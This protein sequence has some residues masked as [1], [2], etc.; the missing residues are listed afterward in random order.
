MIW[1]S[2]SLSA[3][4]SKSI[5]LSVPGSS[6]RAGAGAVTNRLDHAL[7]A[8]AIVLLNCTTLFCSARHSRHRDL[9]RRVHPLPIEPFEQ[10][11][12]LGCREPHHPVLDL[13]PA[14]LALFQPLG[15]ENDARAVPEDQ[16]DPVSSFG[17]EHVNRARERVGAHRLTHKRRE[18]IGPFAEVHRPGRH[19]DANSAG[20]PN[21]GPTFS[22]PITAAIA[23]GLAPDPIRSTVPSISTSI[24]MTGPCRRARRGCGAGGSGGREDGSTTAGTNRAGALG[25]RERRASRRQ[26]NN[27]AGVSPCRRATPHTVRP[28]ASL[29][30]TMAAFSSA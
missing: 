6:G 19:H 10:D 15:D 21:H 16:L 14:E 2:R 13:G 25:P 17:P 20:G 27:C 5:A 3:R 9:P 24:P 7:Q 30:A 22:A 18:A 8:L 12:E 4:S 23:C 28:G 29:S 11:G 1:R 26:V